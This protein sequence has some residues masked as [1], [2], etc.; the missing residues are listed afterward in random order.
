MPC[1]KPLQA[2][3]CSDGRIT[4]NEVTAQKLLR[5]VRRSLMLPCGQCIGCRLEYSRHWA[6]RCMH[7]AQMHAENAF[8]TL[9]YST[10]NLPPGSSLCY[11]DYQLF[12]KRLRKAI[13]R[14]V[15]FYV[16]GEYGENFGRPHFHACLFG[17]GFGDKLY[18]G[19]TDSGFKLYTSALLQR[20]WP[21]GFSSVGD[22]TFESAA[23]VAR[24][25]TKKITGAQGKEHYTYVDAETGELSQRVPEFSRMSLRPPIG[26]RW[27]DK[28][29]T[30]VYPRGLV[31]VNGHE[32]RPPRYYDKV[33]A[34]LD[35]ERFEDLQ[36]AREKSARARYLDN[37]QERLDVKEKVTKARLS[38]LKRSI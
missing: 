13:K 1:F 24:Y 14:P 26:K 6:V 16:A 17:Y 21:F 32:I 22:V 20:L 18:L 29:G 3:Q 27:L 4:F 35:G 23:Y 2:Y 33:F 25:V 11:E 28:F 36:F 31:V 7:E 19:K 5:D 8:I 9:T 34:E 37:V 12:M 15:S 30:D 38:F 10:F